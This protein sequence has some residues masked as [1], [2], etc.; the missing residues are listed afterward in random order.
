M[1]V[2]NVCRVVAMCEE[3]GAPSREVGRGDAQDV[4]V[5]VHDEVLAVIGTASTM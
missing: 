4:G 2:C 5:V 1:C 3:R